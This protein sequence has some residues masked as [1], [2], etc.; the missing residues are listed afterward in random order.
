MYINREVMKDNTFE[1][2]QHILDGFRDE[3]LSMMKKLSKDNNEFNYKNLIL[4][5]D[6]YIKT[7]Y[8][9]SPYIGES[10]MYEP[11]LMNYIF[12]STVVGL[13]TTLNTYGYTYPEFIFNTFKEYL[14][15]GTSDLNF[16]QIDSPTINSKFP[17]MVDEVDSYGNIVNKRRNKNLSYNRFYM[18]EKSSYKHN[19]SY[20]SKNGEPGKTYKPLRLEKKSEFEMITILTKLNVTENTK[21]LQNAIDGFTLNRYESIGI[22]LSKQ[23]LDSYRETYR[24]I[25]WHNP[26][27]Y[28]DFLTMH[29]FMYD[30]YNHFSEF[31]A[32]NMHTLEKRLCF[33]GINAAIKTWKLYAQQSEGKVEVTDDFL[34]ELTSVLSLPSLY[35]RLKHLQEMHNT[36]V[37][38][39]NISIA[40]L[41]K[42]VSDV[43]FCIS[44][45]LSYTIDTILQALELFIANCT[46]AEYDIL[47]NSLTK[48]MDTYSY[49]YTRPTND[50]PIDDETEAIFQTI[51]RN[52]YPP[53]PPQQRS[54]RKPDHKKT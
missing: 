13:Y 18:N 47:L 25:L 44:L 43:L 30:Y 52:L 22:E 34:I 6:S 49:K 14:W 40:T 5:L 12:F 11:Y 20:G 41:Q 53:R 33:Q 28:N 24:N 37:Y 1:A 35:L 39:K 23:Q 50:I 45:K 3:L 17:M 54:K 19:Y 36:M 16:D 46:S 7:I 15:E 21:R 9:V 31:K 48:L 29:Q 42:R 8:Q 27:T 2:H 38:Q 10:V 51:Y 32:L 4:I 26:I